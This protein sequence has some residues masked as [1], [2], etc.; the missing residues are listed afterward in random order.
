SVGVEEQE[1]APATSRREAPSGQDAA[2]DVAGQAPLEVPGVRRVDDGDGSIQ[3]AGLDEL[4]RFLDLEDLGHAGGG[5][6][7]GDGAALGSLG[8]PRVLGEDA[9][10]VA[11]LEGLPG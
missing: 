4:T 11:R 9:L 2:E 7:A 1:L 8:Q 10:G 6:G 3:G 5:S